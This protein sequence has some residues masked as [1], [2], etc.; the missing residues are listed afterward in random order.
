M[1]DLLL[2]NAEL[3]LHCEEKLSTRSDA[4]GAAVGQEKQRLPL[5]DRR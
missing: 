1:K 3:H 4:E 5:T 2:V